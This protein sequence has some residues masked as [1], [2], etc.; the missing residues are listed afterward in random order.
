MTELTCALCNWVWI[1]RVPNPK[2]RRGVLLRGSSVLGPARSRSGL[3]LLAR[4]AHD[5]FS[6][7]SA[8]TSL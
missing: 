8:M 7:Q 1:P 3:G 2:R 5:T 4:A 6:V